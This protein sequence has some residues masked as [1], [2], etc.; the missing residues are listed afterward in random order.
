[1]EGIGRYN[2]DNGEYYIGQFKD[3]S[4]N[5]K[6]IY[7]YK[8]GKIKFDC[9]WY[10]DQIQG[11]GIFYYENDEYYK[12]QWEN[13][14]FQGKGIHYYKDGKIKYNGYWVND[15]REGPKLQ[16]EAEGSQSTLR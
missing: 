11:T 4:R 15:K 9:E 7:Y 3:D 5:G 16:K 12:G 8:N 13:G 14:M 1:M 6:G 2:Y 10:D